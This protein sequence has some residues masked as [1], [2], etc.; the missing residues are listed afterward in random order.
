MS[1]F[2]RTCVRWWYWCSSGTF[3][4]GLLFLFYF[5]AYPNTYMLST[6]QGLA[7]SE[8]CLNWISSFWVLMR[9]C[10]NV[11]LVQWAYTTEWT[12]SRDFFL[13]NPSARHQMC[14]RT[15][16]LCPELFS[17]YWSAHQTIDGS[18]KDRQRSEFCLI[19]QAL[20]GKISGS[21]WSGI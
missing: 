4:L 5:L 9:T 15:V 14:G 1:L 21:L 12:C 7:S 11:L 8:G 19:W 16:I 20:G 3:L 10:S 2:L 17:N 6:L 13:H 18:K